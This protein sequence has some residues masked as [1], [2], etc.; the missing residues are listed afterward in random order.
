MI[1][2]MP[3]T[4]ASNAA[5][6]TA[7]F[8]PIGDARES[9]AAHAASDATALGG[10]KYQVDLARD[11]V[12]ALETPVCRVREGSSAQMLS[13]ALEIGRAHV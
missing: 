8:H 2:D 11:I 6:G 12:S 13:S 9:L 7:Q 10:R 4:D 3:R 1:H 5:H